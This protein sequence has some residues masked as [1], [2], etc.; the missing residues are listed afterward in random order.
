MMDNNTLKK[1]FE[2]GILVD[3]NVSYWS[4]AKAL[5]P[6]D[7]GLDPKQVTSAFKLGKKF[8]VDKNVIQSFRTIEGRARRVVELNSFQF[9]IGHARFVP[10][11]AFPKV[12]TQLKEYQAEY[13]RLVDNL[14][15]NYDKYRQDMVP[16]YRE[17]AEQAFLQSEETGVQE[18]NLDEREAR[19][20]R[21]ITAFLERINGFYPAAESLRGRYRLDWDIYVTSMPDLDQ[22]DS[23]LLASGIVLR[24]TLIAEY[25]QKAKEKISSFVEDVV[26]SL[27]T[28][29]VD[30]CSRVAESIKNGVAINSRT[31]KS[32]REFIDRFQTLNFV[33]DAGLEEQLNSFKK[34]FLDAHLTESI[35]TEDELKTELGRRLHV[36]VEAASEIGDID[37]VT[38]GYRRKIQWQDDPIVAIEADPEVVTPDT[39]T[40]VPPESKA[41]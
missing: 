3:V 31:I 28:Q 7:L 20:S 36:L 16:V 6:N 25:Q 8:L 30:L 5:T 19:K 23:D 39:L 14:V 26:G 32:L 18:F 35:T 27:R 12:L 41:A 10:A 4:G 24:E 17:A 21:Y 15:E 34:E 13:N 40:D 11:K 2:D 33:G 9:P 38:G 22:Q 29:T 37:N 1:V